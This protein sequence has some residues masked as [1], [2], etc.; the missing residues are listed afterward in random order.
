MTFEEELALLPRHALIACVARCARRVQPL[1]EE[2]SGAK[3]R[4]SLEDAIALAEAF[5][6]GKQTGRPVAQ[7]GHR[8]R[9][10]SE[11][12]GRA[13]KRI[14][15][16]G[17]VHVADAVACAARATS[18]ATGFFGH[19][20]EGDK[21]TAYLCA[22]EA[23]NQALH[24]IPSDS[25]AEALIEAAAED[26]ARLRGI[27][28]EGPDQL[29]EPVD[30]SES[31][32]LGSLWPQGAPAWWRNQNEAGD[33]AQSA[34]DTHELVIEIDVPDDYSDRAILEAAREVA[35]L[36]DESHRAQG[37][38]GLKIDRLEIPVRAAVGVPHE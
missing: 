3:H 11:A 21:R 23:F 6:S 31:G 4:R 24:A 27:S 36:A 10:K 1:Y 37:G 8:A 2:Q 5:A 17:A 19:G 7:A 28:H 30:P 13:A 25:E 34:D 16:R 33:C 14:K 18:Y 38:H 22:F 12:A 26:T 20:S 32:P 9:E 29:G 15:A 35:L